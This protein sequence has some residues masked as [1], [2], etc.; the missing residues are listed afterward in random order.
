MGIKNLIFMN[1]N[2]L[3]KL[4]Y[5]TNKPTNMRSWITNHDSL[6]QRGVLA[7]TQTRQD[8]KVSAKGQ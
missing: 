2:I 8:W 7:S 3:D 6:T 4:W 5:T 1:H